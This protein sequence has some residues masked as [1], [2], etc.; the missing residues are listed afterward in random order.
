MVLGA[1][2]KHLKAKRFLFWTEVPDVDISIQELAN[3][4]QGL[5]ISSV[6]GTSNVDDRS[7]S[8]GG[9]YKWGKMKRKYRAKMRKKS[10][11]HTC[12]WSSEEIEDQN[13]KFIEVG[14]C[15][16]LSTVKDYINGIVRSLEGLNL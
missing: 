16:P 8:E 2:T 6:H 10:Y 12:D 11:Q 4:V 9:R 13:V 1:L 7:D 15:D 3:W 14:S 5:R